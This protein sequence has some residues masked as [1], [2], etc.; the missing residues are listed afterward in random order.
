MSRLQSATQAAANTVVSF[1]AI[2]NFGFILDEV[3][4]FFILYVIHKTIHPKEDLVRQR[5]TPVLGGEGA[6]CGS[7]DKINLI[8]N[9]TAYK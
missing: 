2:F 7:G 1:W 3:L 8:D 5:G 9:K 6:R 4:A